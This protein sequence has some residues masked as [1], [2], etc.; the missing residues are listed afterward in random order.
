M[1]RWVRKTLSG[2]KSVYSRFIW[3]NQLGM[4]WQE[5]ADLLQRELDYLFVN[6][7]PSLRSLVPAFADAASEIASFDRLL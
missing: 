6:E 3:C 4:T 2:R 5:L 1:G 7:T